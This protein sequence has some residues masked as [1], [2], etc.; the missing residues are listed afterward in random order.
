MA[1]A[2]WKASKERMSHTGTH[3]YKP[4]KDGASYRCRMSEEDLVQS[5]KWTEWLT[6]Q[7]STATQIGDCQYVA[8]FTIVVSTAGIMH[9]DWPFVINP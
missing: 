7:R 3:R 2:P 4:M 9:F 6:L 1:N 8:S 5:H